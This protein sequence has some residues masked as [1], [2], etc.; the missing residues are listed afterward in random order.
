MVQ[1][2]LIRKRRN[3]YILISVISI[4][5]VWLSA[6]LKHEAAFVF[7]AISVVSLLLLVRQS[8]FLN[9]AMLIWDNRILSIPSTLISLS[10]HQV[11]KE[12]TETVVSTFGML[13]NGKIYCWGLDGIDGVR[14]HAAR[15]DREMMYLTFGDANKTMQIELLHGMTQ[16][17]AVEDTAE[18]LRFETGVTAIISGW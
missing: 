16:R 13:V 12:I 11:K 17:Q 1:M 5:L 8:R 4:C 7:G 15:I 10:G 18:K 14:L 6:A 3:G 2:K 9:Y